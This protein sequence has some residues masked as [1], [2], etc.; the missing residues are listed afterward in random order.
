ML[1]VF[2]CL[3]S[4][5]C[6]ALNVCLFR[7]AHPSC[8]KIHIWNAQGRVCLCVCMC[9]DNISSPFCVCEVHIVHFQ[10]RDCVLLC[11]QDGSWEAERAGRWWRVRTFVRISES[12]SLRQKRQEEVVWNDSP[13]SWSVLFDAL[14]CGSRHCWISFR[15]NHDM[16]GPLIYTLFIFQLTLNDC[17]K[18]CCPWA[19]P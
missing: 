13:S 12:Q 15:Q 2:L 1:I 8:M 16:L 14:S 18:N 3:L 7:C 19:L 4:W 10:A 5:K 6:C 17:H 9:V 11:L